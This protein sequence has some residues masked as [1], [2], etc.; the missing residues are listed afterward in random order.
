MHLDSDVAGEAAPAEDVGLHPRARW[1]RVRA[2]WRR[3]LAALA[4]VLGTCGAVAAA[5]YR[6]G[7][8]LNHTPS[9]PRG[10]YQ[11]ARLT[12]TARARVARGDSVPPRMTMVAWCLPR[13][14][15]DLA[16]ARGYVIRGSCEGGA[17]PILKFTAAV[18][19]DTVTVDGRGLSVNGRRLANSRPVSH[20][21]RGRP[22]PIVPPGTY[23]V[24]SGRAWL[25]S[26]YT[27][28]SFDS[29][30]FG[31]VALAGWVGT[32]R[33]IWTGRAVLP[34]DGGALPALAQ[35]SGPSADGS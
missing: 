21:G 18:P 28:H 19:G 23:P 8:V 5:W 12:P 13:D 10:L 15:S 3:D 4:G 1:P 9:L 7:L 11:L 31:S 26:P 29:R 14:V 24:P 16:R 25:W 30:Y 35:H 20:D 6:S 33:P 27:A 32:V 34:I 2:R 22:V 17:E